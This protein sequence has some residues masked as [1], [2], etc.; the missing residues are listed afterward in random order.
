[1]GFNFGF[2]RDIQ[3]LEKALDPF[4]E[5]LIGFLRAVLQQIFAPLHYVADEVASVALRYLA[6]LHQLAHEIFNLFL[7]QNH[8]ADSSHQDAAQSTEQGI[9]GF[10]RLVCEF[11]LIG[12]LELSRSSAANNR[13]LVVGWQRWG[14][15]LYH[16]AAHYGKWYHMEPR[17]V[18]RAPIED[19]NWEV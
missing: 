8:R 18:K 9:R 3:V 11:N 10:R 5:F 15:R 12:H 16:D 4:L 1:Q 13:R 14:I 2:R 19:G 17:G 7:G 6:P